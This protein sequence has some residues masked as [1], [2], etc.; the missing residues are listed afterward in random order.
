[1]NRYYI[2]VTY[3]DEQFA[4]QAPSPLVV[5]YLE[6]V[7]AFLGQSSC[8]CSVNF[9]SDRTIQE[10]NRE[11]RDKDEP[12]D[13]LS[14]VQEED[15]EDFSWPEVQL[16]MPDSPPEEIRVLGDMVISLDA[17]KRNALS[18][19]VEPDEELFR[20]LIHGLLHLL[21]EDHSSNDAD[22]PMLIKQEEILHQLGGSKR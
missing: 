14:F 16:G 5:E 19:S 18:F 6:N 9:V 7:L 3:E 21:G 10:L 17:L 22:E 8:E 12:T 2:D 13:I 1:M 11:Y 15:I 20:L 4:V